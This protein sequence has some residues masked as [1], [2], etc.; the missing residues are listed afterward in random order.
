MAGIASLGG[1]GAYIGKVSNDQLGGVFRH[2][3][4]AIG[5]SF[6]TQAA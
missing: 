1:K 3:I 6:D 2:D 5:V 4:R